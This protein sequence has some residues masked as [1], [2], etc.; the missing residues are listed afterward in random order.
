M[1]LFLAALAAF[2]VPMIILNL[3]LDAE[4]QVV[5]EIFGFWLANMLL[6]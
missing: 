1:I 4:S 3:N 2:G 6:N 5:D